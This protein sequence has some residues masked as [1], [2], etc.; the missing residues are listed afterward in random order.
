MSLIRFVTRY[1][2]WYHVVGVL[3][4]V[5][6]LTGLIWWMIERDRGAGFRYNDE[7]DLVGRG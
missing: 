1:V 5:T 6:I 7:T 2:R 4:G 3:T